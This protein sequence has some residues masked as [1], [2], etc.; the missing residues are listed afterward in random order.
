MSVLVVLR[1]CACVG[2]CVCVRVY[3]LVFVCVCV[4]KPLCVL[5]CASADAREFSL[6]R[7]SSCVYV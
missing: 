7:V 3:V 2:L 4:W 5:V 1:V 6:M